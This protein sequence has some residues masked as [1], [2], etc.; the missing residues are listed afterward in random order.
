MPRARK[1]LV[2]VSETPC[3][4]VP[5]RCVRRA[6]LC[7]MDRY[8]GKSYEHRRSWVE[9]CLRILSSIFSI[10]VCADVVMSNNYHLVVRLNPSE[11]DQ[12]TDEA[13]LDRWTSLFRGS[14]LVQRHQRG[15]A[16]SE[17]ELESLKS[18]TSVY[19]RRLGSLS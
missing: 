1:H 15:E 7:G 2:C 9:D 8:S 19:R 3:Y 16:L 11:S 18:T 4:H 14:L 13:V 10:S 12:W 5:A 6:Y 17:I